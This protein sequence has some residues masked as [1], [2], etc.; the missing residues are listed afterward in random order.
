MNVSQCLK[1]EK[2]VTAVI[3]GG[4]K[5]TLTHVLARELAPQGKVVITTTTKIWPPQEIPYLLEPTESEIAAALEK[6]DVIC[7][8]KPHETGKLTACSIPVSRL[9]E[10]CDYLLVEADGSAGLPLKGHG[11]NEPQIPP[12][13]NQTVLV[14]GVWG[15]GQTV[16]AATHRPAV[17]AALAQVGTE[18][19]V[20]AEIAAKVISAENLHTRVF[21]NGVEDEER[22]KAARAIAARLDCPV[23][24]G[25]LKEG[26]YQCLF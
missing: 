21:I 5:T 24:I 23:V 12:E 18:D 2:G 16:A 1:I 17:Y 22:E 14:L 4:G 19:A 11:E 3:G 15:I 7:V 13:S 9:A 25:A 8:G 6:E 10:L 26:K 20:T